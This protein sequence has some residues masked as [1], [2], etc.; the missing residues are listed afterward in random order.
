MYH[1]LHADKRLHV[2]CDTCYMQTFPI[3]CAEN[4]T[5]TTIGTFAIMYI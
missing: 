5:E 1:M 2:A 3:P 4:G